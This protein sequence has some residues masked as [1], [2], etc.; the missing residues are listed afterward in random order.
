V[1][2]IINRHRLVKGWKK[3]YIMHLDR[4]VATIK[5]NG[6][7]TIY[8]PSFMPYNLS[9]KKSND[10]DIRVE[11]LNNFYHWCSSRV[12]SRDRA[13]SKE[14]L[15]SIGASQ[16]TTDKDRAAIAISY[17]GLSLID[18]YWI[19]SSNEKVSFAEINLYDH[20]LSE[21][22]VNVS[23]YGQQL[24]VQN[25]QM[26]SKQDV[27]G[28]VATSGVAP[29]AWVRRNGNFYLLKDGDERDVEAELLASRIVECFELN[30]VRYLEKVFE[31]KKVSQSKI[32]TSKAVSI[33]SMEYV[34][35]YCINHDKDFIEFVLDKDAYSY[36]MMNIVDYL[37]GNTDRHWG[38]WGF[39]V[40]NSSN[41]LTK[42]HALMDF[43]KAF[44]SYQTLDGTVCKTV[45]S[46]QMS[47]KDAAIEAVGKIGLN[48]I[49]DVNPEWFGDEKTKEMFFRR[50]SVLKEWQ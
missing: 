7:C 19:K 11:N 26:I 12:I 24:T 21:A 25:T 2:A 35:V 8:Y 31:G 49:R 34:D 6:D 1:S 50:L 23:L 17:H 39:A 5:E 43:N 18:V 38:N 44:T 13:Y 40:D 15:N 36:Y 41:K 14:I 47:Q 22:F 48:Q 45:G 20:S 46:R 33:V 29:K 3:Y 30:A 37:V 27:A 9:L 16:S 4:H 32:I 28:D 42:L 10:I